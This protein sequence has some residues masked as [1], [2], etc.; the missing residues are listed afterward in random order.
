MR[1]SQHGFSKEKPCRTNPVAFRD[2]VTAPLAKERATDVIHPAFCEVFGIVPHSAIT[3]C[4]PC[5]LLPLLKTGL[6]LLGGAAS[7]AA[8]GYRETWCCHWEQV[9]CPDKGRVGRMVRRVAGVSA[10]LCIQLCLWILHG[11]ICPGSSA[12]NLFPLGKGTEESL[13][14]TAGSTGSDSVLGMA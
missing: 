3:G 6:G 10:A 2:G 9:Q 4:R 11:S 1:D 5:G 13:P 14:T 7:G 8:E 12:E